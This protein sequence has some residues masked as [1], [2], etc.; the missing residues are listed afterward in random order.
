VLLLL[1]QCDE[2][3]SSAHDPTFMSINMINLKVT[4]SL[5]RKSFWQWWSSCVSCSWIAKEGASVYVDEK[6]SAWEREREMKK[7]LLERERERE[8]WM[9][10]LTFN[11]E[12]VVC[13]VWVSS[14]KLNEKVQIEQHISN[15]TH[16]FW[17][18]MLC[19]KKLC[20]F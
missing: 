15:K 9:I 14:L 16:M 12:I 20:G 13:H 17:L 2:L 7:L 6:T 5:Y 11:G 8:I 3:L 18:K 1:D 19:K 10:E 4:G